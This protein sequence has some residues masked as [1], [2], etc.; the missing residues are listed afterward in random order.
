MIAM[1]RNGMVVIHRCDY[2][3]RDG[4]KDED[5]ARRMGDGDIVLRINPEAYKDIADAREIIEWIRKRLESK[6]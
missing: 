2:L 5:A 6:E 3:R 1:I 4:A